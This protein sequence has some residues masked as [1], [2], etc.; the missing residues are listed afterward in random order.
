MCGDFVCVV[1]YF[2]VVIDYVFDFVEGYNGWVIV[3]F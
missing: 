1:E 2:I 3:F